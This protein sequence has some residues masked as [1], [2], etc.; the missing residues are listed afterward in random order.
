MSIT[1]KATNEEIRPF[2]REKYLSNSDL[3]ITE[4]EKWYDKRIID[5]EISSKNIL[6]Q[7]KCNP[8][9]YA[10]DLAYSGH[11][12]ITFSPDMIWLLITQGI[13]Q[14]C[15]LKPEEARKFFVDHEGKK[16]LIV[17]RDDFRLEGGNPW[18]EVFSAFID[19]MQK[20]IGEER[21]KDFIPKFSTTLAL[22]QTCF[23]LSLMDIMKNY[24]DYT[25]RT[26]CA[27]TQITLEGEKADWELLKEKAGNLRKYDLGWW[28]EKL[29]KVLQPFIDAF[30]GNIDQKFWEEF[31]K[32]RGGSGGPYTQGHILNFFPYV[33]EKPN[34]D[35]RYCCTDDLPSGIAQIPMKWEYFTQEFKMTLFSG[36]LGVTLSEGSLKP[37]LGWAVGREIERTLEGWIKYVLQSCS[38]TCEKKYLIDALAGKDDYWAIRNKRFPVFPKAEIEA[39]IEKMIGKG[40]LSETRKYNSLYLELLEKFEEEEDV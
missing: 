25:L 38:Q 16:E 18:P 37:C 28:A 2:N 12:P 13:A 1:F 26:V 10:V 19:K 6:S 11:Y 22:E 27:M 4:I 9:I 40:V 33:N 20:E 3:I 17:Q 34:I 15:D 24:F 29:E 8:F 32:E 36:F 7:P 30:D 23:N 39:E 5:Y 21:V 14:H 31:Y 35:L